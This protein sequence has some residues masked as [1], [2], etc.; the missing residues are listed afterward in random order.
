MAISVCEVSIT[1][2]PLD[3]PARGNDSASGAVVDFW[4]VV[5]GLEEGKEISGIE[6]EAHLA[7]AEHQMRQIA[8]TATGKYNLA[9]VVIRHRIGFVPAGQASVVVRVESARRLNAF[10]ANQ[11]IMDE[12]KRMVPIWKHP[13]FKESRAPSENSTEKSQESSACV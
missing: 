4:G 2:A 1:Q 8:E 6:Y 10:A 3:L 7:M 5:R 11:W 13:V 12:L 9:K